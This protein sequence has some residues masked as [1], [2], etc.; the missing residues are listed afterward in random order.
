MSRSMAARRRNSVPSRTANREYVRDPKTRKLT[1]IKTPV[2]EMFWLSKQ[3]HVHPVTG[4]PYTKKGDGVTVRRIVDRY[5]N[6]SYAPQ[7]EHINLQKREDQAREEMLAK[8]AEE[9]AETESVY[10]DDQD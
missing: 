3:V 10:H 2:G 4:M 5:G 6:T 7:G 9:L 8:A 1:C